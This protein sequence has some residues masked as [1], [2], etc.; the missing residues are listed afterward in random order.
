[1]GALNMTIYQ[2]LLGAERYRDVE[3]YIALFH[4]EAEIVFHKSGNTFSKTEWASMVADM[5][6]NPKFVFESSRCVYEND[7]IMVSHDFMSYPD[8]TRE[9]VMVVAML[10]DGQIIRIETGATLLD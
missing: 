10:K 2:R 8:D 5:L 9:A 3:S 7:E 1:M 4:R 6:A